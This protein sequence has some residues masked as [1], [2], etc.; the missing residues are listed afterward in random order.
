[1]IK[2]YQNTDLGLVEKPAFRYC[3]ETG[4]KGIIMCGHF[5]PPDILHLLTRVYEYARIHRE[6]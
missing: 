1:M 3:L 5:I 6:R 2:S 4:D